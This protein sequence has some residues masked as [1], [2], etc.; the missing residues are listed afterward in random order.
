MFKTNICIINVD[1]VEIEHTLEVILK[2][3]HVLISLT[4]LE[5][6]IM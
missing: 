6:D 3:N 4:D 2:E 1:N 5:N